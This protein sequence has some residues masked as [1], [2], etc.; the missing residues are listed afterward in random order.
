[1]YPAAFASKRPCEGA[2]GLVKAHL[3]GMLPSLLQELSDWTPTTRGRGAA[4]LLALIVYAEQAIAPHAEAL[5][6]AFAKAYM[7]DDEHVASRV[8]ECVCLA[9]AFVPAQVFVG[10]IASHVNGG[11]V[12][13]ASRRNWMA[14]LAA[15]LEG[16]TEQDIA[17]LLP[18]VCEM[19]GE[20]EL[21]MPEEE[22]H[23]VHLLRVLRACVSSGGKSCWGVSGQLFASFLRLESMHYLGMNALSAGAADGI[24]RLAVALELEGGAKELFE[25]EAGGVLAGAMG[26]RSEWRRDSKDLQVFDTLLRSGGGAVVPL[27]DTCMPA[28]TIVADMNRDADVRSTLLVLLD[29]LLAES[30]IQHNMSPFGASL[31]ADVIVPVCVWRAGKVASA[32]RK[33]GVS[34]MK[35]LMAQRLVKPQD[36]MKLLGEGFAAGPL[37]PVMK[38][39]MDDDDA[40]I[41]YIACGAAREMFAIVAEMLDTEQV[42]HFY[43]E[44]LRRL[45]D[46]NDTIRCEV[47][48]AAR[49]F[50]A[51]V[52]VGYDPA[53]YEYLLRNLVVHL[54]DQNEAVQQ[55]VLPAVL[56]AAPVNPALF[57]TVLRECKGKHRSG[58]MCQEALDHVAKLQHDSSEILE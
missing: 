9:G 55:A 30:G 43:L 56:A 7:D 52:P 6:G 23:Q 32:L 12:A 34:C 16:A 54:D 53:Q 4:T 24:Q 48:T 14:V 11:A 29:F 2:R 36:V 1:M 26:T 40:D 49:T 20:M 31:L 58:K 17:P 39:C 47:A 46:S 42:R 57:T 21:C 44:L 37:D 35:H 19:V 38:S 45:D 50:M 18:K 10:V 41:R 3:D 13:A 51:S 27:L 5:V 8:A 22:E 33:A 28:F 15:L 25:R